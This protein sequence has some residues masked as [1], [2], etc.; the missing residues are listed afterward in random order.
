MFGQQL[1][2]TDIKLRPYQYAAIGAIRDRFEAGDRST[3]LILPTGTGKTVT[4]GY[5]AYTLAREGKRT[6]ILAHR[7]ELIDQAAETL[8]RLG[9]EVDIEKAESYARTLGDPHAVVATVQTLQR[10]RLE[11]WPRDYFDLVVTDEAHH[12]TADSY[13][14]IYRHF[15]AKHLGVT[16]TADRS[17]DDHLSAVFDSV[18]Y[19]LTLWD[20]MT[21]EAPGPYLSR[22][23]FV[24]CDVG[25]DLRDIRT[26]AGDLNAGDLEEAIRPHVEKL[27]N[28][29]KQE[30]GDRR[31]LVFTPDVGSAQAMASAFESIGVSARW[32]SGDDADRRTKVAAY[33]AGEFQ[34]L[35][36]CALLTEGFDAPETAAIV[37]C[38][39]TKSRSLYAQMVGRGTRLAPGKTNCLLIDFN[40]LTVKHDLVKPYELFD[41]S[42]TGDE[43]QKVARELVARAAKAEA[44]GADL[45]EI[46]EQ[47]R[48]EAK[49]RIELRVK[50]RERAVAYRRVSY[51]PLSAM[52]TLGIPVRQEAQSLIGTAT[53][54]QKSTL[55]KFGVDQVETLSRRRAS[56]LLDQCIGR[57][58][59]GLATFKQVSH[60]I[61]NGVEPEQ[62]RAMSVKAA[63]AFL[64]EIWG[65][66]KPKPQPR[67]AAAR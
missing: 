65:E 13:A 10:K 36:N 38:R 59:A 15:D 20:A 28:A 51:D 67:R 33:K 56:V 60:L 19:E 63:S 61:R 7:S 9:L 17:D 21:A 40:W 30:I 2:P 45:L 46:V 43:E 1:R 4:F 11:S 31:G 42:R 34:L 39:P 35:C 48:E 26:T 18:A 66:R 54:R 32:V 49:R 47:A 6:L 27:A 5:Y 14:N 41:S 58:K 55:A 12:A 50:T 22:L 44:D 8:S 37:L 16:A 52:E 53:D 62:A 25:I 64:S 24:Q 57:S 23:R 3:L 29:V